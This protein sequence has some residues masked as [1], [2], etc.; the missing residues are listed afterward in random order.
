MNLSQPNIGRDSQSFQKINGVSEIEEII[1]SVMGE[2]TDTSIPYSIL[3][4]TTEDNRRNHEVMCHVFSWTVINYVGSCPRVSFE[5]QV[6]S[7]IYHKREDYMVYGGDWQPVAW[8]ITTGTTLARTLRDRKE[9]EAW[10]KFREVRPGQ[11]PYKPQNKEV[12]DFTVEQRHLTVTY[13]D[14]QGVEP[15]C[16][17]FE[18]NGKKSGSM[19]RYAEAKGNLRYMPVHIRKERTRGLELV[20]KFYA[21]H[22]LLDEAPTATQPEQKA[23]TEK[24]PCPYCGKKFTPRGLPRHMQSCSARPT[25]EV[26]VNR[27]AAPT[28]EA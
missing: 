24:V 8:S 14:I 2:L 26:S 10:D 12:V 6:R 15:F 11:G 27:F 3:T 23:V 7:A 4:G 13:A 19:Y 21:Y 18:N 16:P 22:G 28:G 1:E 25:E 20:K 17:L 9:V 5:D